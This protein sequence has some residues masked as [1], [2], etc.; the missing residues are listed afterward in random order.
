MG[1]TTFKKKITSPELIEQINPKNVKLINLFLKEKD[2]KC[3]DATIKVYKSNFIRLFLSYSLYTYYT[4][5]FKKNQSNS[6]FEML[7]GFSISTFNSLSAPLLT[8]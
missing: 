2:R 3:S 4:I 1:R 7:C 6:I 8:L 5:L